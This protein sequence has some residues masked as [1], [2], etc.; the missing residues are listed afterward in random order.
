MSWFRGFEVAHMGFTS[1][2][3]PNS[4]L[5]DCGGNSNHMMMAARSVHPGGVQATL[6]DGSVRFFTESINLNTWR[7]LGGAKDGVSVTFE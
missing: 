2:M 1:V 5:W 6:V 4:N 7:F 3:T